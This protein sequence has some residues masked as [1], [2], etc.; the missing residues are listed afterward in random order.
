MTMCVE[1]STGQTVFLK[2]NVASEAGITI[3]GA[4]LGVCLLDLSPSHLA[5]ARGWLVSVD[6]V[7]QIGFS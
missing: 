5:L 4:Q 6:A 3:A 1:F 7:M 2:G